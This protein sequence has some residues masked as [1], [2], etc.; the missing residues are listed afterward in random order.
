[1]TSSPSCEA[2]ETDEGGGVRTLAERERGYIKHRSGL[3][4]ACVCQSVHMYVQ[5]T[6]CR[7]VKDLA[8]LH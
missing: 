7:S 1:M 4:W 8:L 5:L 3:L 6:A 2:E